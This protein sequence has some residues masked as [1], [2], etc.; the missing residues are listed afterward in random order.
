MGVY[1]LK[2]SLVLPLTPPLMGQVLTLFGLLSGVV[3]E[4]DPKTFISGPA[5]SFHRFPR[6]LGTTPTLGSSAPLGLLVLVGLAR[7][8]LLGS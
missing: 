2:A 8:G 3:S 1:L 4:A 6:T 5:P 7:L